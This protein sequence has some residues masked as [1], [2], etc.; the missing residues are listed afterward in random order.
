MVKL[1]ILNFPIAHFW[2]RGFFDIFKN[3]VIFDCGQALALG[4]GLALAL[5]LPLALELA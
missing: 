5:G 1:V 2:L 4:L 3:G